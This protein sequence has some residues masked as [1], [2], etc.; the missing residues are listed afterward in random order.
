MSNDFD[1]SLGLEGPNW[2]ALVSLVLSIF[3]LFVTLPMCC[4]LGVAGGVVPI[5]GGTLAFGAALVGVWWE[6][7]SPTSDPLLAWTAVGVSVVLVLFGLATC[8]SSAAVVLAM[9]ATTT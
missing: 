9:L 7:S 3:S 6:R 2:P 5:F 1:Q 4:V 8:G